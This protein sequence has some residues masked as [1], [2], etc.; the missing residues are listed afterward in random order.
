MEIKQFIP[1]QQV[2]D[3]LKDMVPRGIVVHHTAGSR[4]QTMQSLHDW[5]VVGRKNEGYVAIGYH[6]CIYENGDIYCTRPP[7]KIGGHAPGYNGTHIGIS[8]VGDFTKEKPTREAW[9][10]FTQACMYLM[11]TYNFDSSAIIPHVE[12]K[13]LAKLGS[14][15]CP[16]HNI[17]E[18]LKTPFIP[19][20][21]TLEPDL[22]AF[23]TK[24]LAIEL[25]N[26][27]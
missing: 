15:A 14:T 25:V 20:K 4:S 13:K 23:T 27:L 17:L 9:N 24:E 8:F 16:G 6:Y 1:N 26:R 10:A 22:S 2:I 12:A 5:F 18:L 21:K 19:D 7:T 3:E 11:E